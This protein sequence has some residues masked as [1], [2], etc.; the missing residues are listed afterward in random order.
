MWIPLVPIV[1]ALALLVGAAADDE[2]NHLARRR[3]LEGRLEVEGL[4]LA[5]RHVGVRGGVEAVKR[6]HREGS[7]KERR[8]LRVDVLDSLEAAEYA[9][10]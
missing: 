8:V 6:D 3:P 9:P 1:N 2:D 10:A 4:V 5:P 7:G